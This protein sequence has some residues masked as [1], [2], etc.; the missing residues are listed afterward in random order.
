MSARIR[1]AESADIPAVRA[2]LAATWHATYDALFGAERVS[3]M[4][5]AW[6][7]EENLGR[8]WEEAE[9]FPA[10]RIFLVAGEEHALVATAS[11][12][13][14]DAETV[15]LTRLYVLPDHQRQRLGQSMLERCLGHFPGARRAQLQVVAGNASAVAFYRRHGFVEAATAPEAIEQGQ[16]DPACSFVMERLLP[17][18]QPGH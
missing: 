17:L 11:A 4:T 14:L 1:S 5:R 15:N 18:F 12:V 7:S 16:R 2:L 3:A 13:M 8:E 10:K 6:H 9:A